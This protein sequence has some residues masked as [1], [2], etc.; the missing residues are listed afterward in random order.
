MGPVH[1]HGDVRWP[2][3]GGGLVHP[4]AGRADRYR[5]RG[6]R[7]RRWPDDFTLR[8][9][10]SARGARGALDRDPHLAHAVCRLPRATLA[11]M[12]RSCDRYRRHD[13]SG[14]GVGT[15]AARGGTRDSAR[16][17]G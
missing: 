2:D 12:D 4:A 14:H 17:Y 1:L 9:H 3:R 6:S 16:L 8:D 11:L 10:G 7:G 13:C 5:H 15:A